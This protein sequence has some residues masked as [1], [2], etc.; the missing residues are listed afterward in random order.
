M[1]TIQA[2]FD[3]PIRENPM[4]E[5]RK[6]ALKLDFDLRLKLEFKGTKATSDAGL[7]A[8]RELDDA[9][10]LTSAINSELRDIRT[11]KNTQHDIAACRLQ[12]AGPRRSLMPSARERLMRSVCI[13]LRVRG[14]DCIGR[15]TPPV[16][17]PVSPHQ[18]NQRRSQNGAESS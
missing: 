18:V 14:S 1:E 2:G 7:P 12:G 15:G 6:D 4:G 9:L 13:Q 10:G 16:V 11:G 3:H 5:A 8:Y 17:R